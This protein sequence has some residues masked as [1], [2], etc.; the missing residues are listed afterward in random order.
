MRADAAFEAVLGV[1]LIVGFGA[2]DFPDPVGRP[3]VLAVGAALLVIGA[4]LWHLCD[5]FDLRTL[6]IANLATAAA[7]LVWC[8]AASGFSTAG[9]AVTIG[10]AVALVLLGA[11]QLALSR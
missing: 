3:L 5:T 10:T 7:A 6:A 9:A 8:F 11:V 2:S 4:V 1:V